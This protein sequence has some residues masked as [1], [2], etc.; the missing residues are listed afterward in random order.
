MTDYIAGWVAGAIYLDE[1][2]TPKGQLP[3]LS[4]YLID[5]NRLRTYR[6]GIPRRYGV[7]IRSPDVGY[8]LFSF[9]TLAFIDGL[10]DVCDLYNVEAK[11]IVTDTVFDQNGNIVLIDD[12]EGNTNVLEYR[13]GTWI[14]IFSDETDEI[15]NEMYDENI[16]EPYRNPDI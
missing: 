2:Y 6:Y 13:T 10:I 11:Y 1:N 8:N 7:W 12:G 4:S 9:D 16:L 5:M 15:I 3:D 14:N